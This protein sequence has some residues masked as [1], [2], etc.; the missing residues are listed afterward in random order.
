MGEGD[1]NNVWNG[2]TYPLRRCISEVPVFEDANLSQN[3]SVTC[4]T[5]SKETDSIASDQKYFFLF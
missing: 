1:I 3:W 2:M 4:L 5:S